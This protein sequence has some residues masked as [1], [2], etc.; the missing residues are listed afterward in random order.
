[1]GNRNSLP[2]IRR[3]A[4]EG[5]ILALLT[6]EETVEKHCIRTCRRGSLVNQTE[7]P[8]SVW[9]RFWTLLRLLAGLVVIS[10]CARGDR[11]V[12]DGLSVWYDQNALLV[13]KGDQLK[14]VTIDFSQGP[15][16]ILGIQG[17]SPSPC[18]EN[19]GVDLVRFEEG[20]LLRC[21]NGDA[22]QLSWGASSPERTDDPCA[23]KGSGAGLPQ[24]CT[25]D[26][27]AAERQIHRWI[28]RGKEFN[29][30]SVVFDYHGRD[31]SMRCTVGSRRGFRVAPLG[32]S[33]GGYADSTDMRVAVVAESDG[34]SGLV[35]LHHVGFSIID[36]N[37][38][39]QPEIK[40]R[41]KRIIM[42]PDLNTQER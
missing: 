26:Q 41:C 11:G 38:G 30:N 25:L 31:G 33:I 6:K 4:P 18:P 21:A 14:W 7:T 10:G 3:G 40:V 23:P 32:F 13:V 24:W 35:V 15:D 16:P 28:D 34:A 5:S 42:V 29:N 9:R 27:R 2:K 8:V 39:E 22:Y 20:A 12:T 36:L 1:M 19:S 37:D 17:T